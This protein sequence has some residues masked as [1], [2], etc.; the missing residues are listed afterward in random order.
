MKTKNKRGP[1]ADPCGTTE[2]IFLFQSDVWP[3]NTTL[4]LRLWR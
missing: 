1:N 4:C 3:F 2:F